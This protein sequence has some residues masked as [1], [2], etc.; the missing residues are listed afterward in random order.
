MRL[1]FA[2]LSVWVGGAPRS[3]VALFRETGAQHFAGTGA[4]AS[5]DQ[6]H[7]KLGDGCGCQP[8]SPAAAAP[9]AV[10][11]QNEA[12]GRVAADFPLVGVV[13]FYELT[14]PRFD[15]HE[16]PF[17]SFGHASGPQPCCDCTHYCYTPQ[18]WAAW[19]DDLYAATEAHSARRA[20]AHGGA[21]VAR[22]KRRAGE[23]GGRKRGGGRAGGQPHAP[24]GEETSPAVH[25]DAAP[26]SEPHTLDASPP[27]A[28][29]SAEASAAA[30]PPP[31]LP[32]SPPHRPPLP[33]LAP[34]PPPEPS[35]ASDDSLWV[36]SVD[37]GYQDFGTRSRN[38]PPGVN[39]G[40]E[41]MQALSPRTAAV[42]VASLEPERAAPVVFAMRRGF[43][44][45]VLSFM[46]PGEAEAILAVGNDTW[47]VGG[48]R[49]ARAELRAAMRAAQTS[50]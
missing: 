8:L 37:V 41:A 48:A 43:A 6:A 38:Y 11:S 42:F 21:A 4:F 16:G 26:P 23:A 12:V 18:L 15:M 31:L 25:I 49:E 27:P 22:A 30:P 5:W 35:S 36:N 7:P 13:P 1:L 29:A 44:A 17:C 34:H 28:V 20:G 10:K 47:P 39:V 9:N 45:D 14:A 32:P 2:Q 40:A 33:P 24:A 3:R 19:F 50:G 46:A